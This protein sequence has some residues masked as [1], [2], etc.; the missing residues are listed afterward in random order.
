MEKKKR[1]LWPIGIVLAMGTFIVGI[2]VAVT[3]MFK[4]DVPL[5]SKDYYA[6]EIAYQG[7]IDKSSRGLAPSQKPEIRNL[8]ATGSLEII[9]P[10]KKQSTE[11]SGKVVFFRPA[12]PK[13]DFEVGLSPDTTGSQWIDLRQK[14][15]G[16]W[17]VQ[18]DWNEDGTPYYF[19][20]QLLI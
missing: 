18:I 6:K 16:L 5:T 11:F 3:I 4:N 13:M 12:D 1:E 2:V 10:G 19:E 17:M 8:T 9:F 7:E 15:K 20:Q 14:A